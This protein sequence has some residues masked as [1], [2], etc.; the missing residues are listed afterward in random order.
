MPNNCLQSECKWRRTISFVNQIHI[1]SNILSNIEQYQKLF[2]QAYLTSVS[3]DEKKF[4]H[5]FI[6]HL[7]H[8]LYESAPRARTGSIL[9]V[10][11]DL[12]I[13]NLSLL[14]ISDR[15]LL[16]FYR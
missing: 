9:S 13:V 1:Y 14:L 10:L 11:P 15:V 8:I 12:F 3:P 7:K 2:I 6:R 4:I 16:S 5:L